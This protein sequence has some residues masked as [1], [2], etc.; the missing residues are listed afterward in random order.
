VANSSTTKE[1]CMT[2]H[3]YTSVDVIVVGA[4]M[5]GLSCANVLARSGVDVLVF[6]ARDRVG[7]R[8]DSVEVDGEVV[9]LGGQF[10]GPGQDRAY[11][12]AAE[13]GVPVF[14]TYTTGVHLAEDAAG[15]IRRFRGTVPRLQLPAL[16]DFAQA[17]ARFERLART[18]DVEAPW[19]T[20]G[21]ERWDALSLA[22]W[23]HR[24]L[25]TTGGR[26]LFTLA[27]RLL[28]ACEPSELSL[29][30]ALFYARAAGSL[31]AVMATE[32]G[33][34]QDLLDGGAHALAVRL[35]D[36][37]G[38]RVR[39]S[40]P[41]RHIAYHDGGVVVTA[42]SGDV[43]PAAR[44]VVAVPPV[45]AGRIVY[46]P[47]LPAVRDGLTQR[48]AMGATI[49]CMV[50]YPE[51]FW[52]TAGLSG[53][54]LSL[55]GPVA[56]VADSSPRSG[57]RGILVS[58]LEGAAARRLA[59]RPADERRSLVVDE[60]VRL[61]GPGAADPAAYIEQDWSAEPYTLG[62]YAA[63]FPTGA[64][65]QFGPALRTPVGPIHWAGSETATRWYGYI[66]GA[67]R[68][69]EAAAAAVQSRP[70]GGGVVTARRDP[71]PGPGRPGI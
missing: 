61:F 32:N 10:V 38:D 59:G 52:R 33:A 31:R 8:T 36:R 30:H 67:I 58:V 14:P 71:R 46:D 69:G 48:L 39:L 62:A 41:V 51:P 13:L 43:V 68:S 49:K 19:R 37:L 20:R 23:I 9:D 3:P 16:L 25:H 64:W 50:V 45:L 29:L 35:A 40:T 47:P 42:E 18:V 66:D 12:L 27:A 21:A 60:L 15:R 56:A 34:Q 6:E 65:T 4:G 5:A 17:Q 63:L 55:R 24:T 22:A 1:F 53:H 57:R 7:G 54:A 70:S 2:H 26:Q 28:W 11:A 44:V